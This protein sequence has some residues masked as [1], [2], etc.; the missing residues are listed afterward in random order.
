LVENAAL[1]EHDQPL[2]LI[3]HGLVES[4]NEPE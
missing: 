4:P 2:I 3:E 1:V